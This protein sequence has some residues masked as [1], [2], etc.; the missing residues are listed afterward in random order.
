[1]VQFS[2]DN[3]ATWR[4]LRVNE[5]SFSF[6]ANPRF[7]PGGA[8]CRIRVIASDGFN[9]ATAMSQA[10]ALP[11]H[12]PEPFIGGVRDGQRLPFGTTGSLLGFALDAEDGSLPTAGLQWDLTGPTPRTGTGG[13]L[14]LSDLS[15]GV[16]TATLSTT[17]THGNPGN[18]TLIFEIL[19]LV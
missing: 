5:G 14:V 11:G 1:S 13:S 12:A 9:S 10:F 8:Q 3:G 7:L 15:P 16:Y 18:K 17:D 6:T 19:P 2:N 4:T